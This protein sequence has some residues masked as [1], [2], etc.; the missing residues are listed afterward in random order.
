MRC[1][2][3]E[4]F[5]SVE[6]EVEGHRLSGT[7]E[8][9]CRSVFNVSS[10]KLPCHGSGGTHDF[11]VNGGEFWPLKVRAIDVEGVLLSSGLE[12]KELLQGSLVIVGIKI[13]GD[14]G[15]DIFGDVGA[16]S[17]LLGDVPV[18]ESVGVRGLRG[19]IV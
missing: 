15:W 2:S 12:E 4:R 1:W 6:G 13:V 7:R 3:V 18:N 9:I 19:I 14:G 8:P 17:N 16:D 10:S 11:S 5:P